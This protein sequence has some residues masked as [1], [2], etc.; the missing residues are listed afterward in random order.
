VSGVKQ[1]NQ[2][3]G[4]VWSVPRKE[5]KTNERNPKIVEYVTATLDVTY[6]F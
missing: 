4:A 2:E 6:M 3:L 1:I 5:K